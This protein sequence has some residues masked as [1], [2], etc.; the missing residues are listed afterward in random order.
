EGSSAATACSGAL[1]RSTGRQEAARQGLQT[2]GTPATEQ[3]GPPGLRLPSPTG[4]LHPVRRLRSLLRRPVQ[5]SG[6]RGPAA[7]PSTRS[8]LRQVGPL[9]VVRLSPSADRFVRGRDSEA[10]QSARATAD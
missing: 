6:H 4:D 9:L 5:G 3:T 1:T 2:A 10:W 7:D 8:P